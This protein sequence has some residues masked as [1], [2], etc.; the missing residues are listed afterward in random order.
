[1]YQISARD[2][3]QLNHDISTEIEKVLLKLV[4]D[5]KIRVIPGETSIKSTSE[6][7]KRKRGRPRKIKTDEKS[8][9]KEKKPR[10]RP[11]KVKSDGLK[12]ADGVKRK[13]RQTEKKGN[14]RT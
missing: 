12:P 11:R 6:G 2:F 1:M 3:S 5:G 10:G 13:T 14:T 7:E 4:S 9:Q 8:G